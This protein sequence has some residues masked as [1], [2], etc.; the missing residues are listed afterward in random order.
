VVRAEGEDDLEGAI[1]ATIVAEETHHD[2]GIQVLV[3][4]PGP[5]FCAIL[6]FRND[7]GVYP[8]DL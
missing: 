3:T 7:D 5:I 2:V 8:D 1:N 6:T 4:S